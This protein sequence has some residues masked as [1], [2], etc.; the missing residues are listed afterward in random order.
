MNPK[1]AYNRKFDILIRA[2]AFTLTITFLSQ[3]IAWSYPD[4]S[5]LNHR[6]SL[7][8]KTLATTEDKV[9][10]FERV[11]LADIN[12]YIFGPKRDTYTLASIKQNLW[13]YI[14]SLAK[15]HGLIEGQMPKISDND[16][17]SDGF[18]IMTF[19]SGYEVLFYDPSIFKEDRRKE[20]NLARRDILNLPHINDYLSVQYSAQAPGDRD[21]TRLNDRGES[22]RL[23]DL[24]SLYSQEQIDRIFYEVLTKQVIN[25]YHLTVRSTLGE[26][27]RNEDIPSDIKKDLHDIL[28]DEYIKR[29]YGIEINPETRERIRRWHTFGEETYMTTRGEAHPEEYEI[30]LI[31]RFFTEVLEFPEFSNTMKDL[32]KKKKLNVLHVEDEGS[33][34]DAHAS[35]EFGINVCSS[36]PEE[37]IGPAIVHELMAY[38]GFADDTFN[39]YVAEIYR[40]CRKIW[41]GS[42][43]THIKGTNNIDRIKKRIEK[44]FDQQAKEASAEL[45]EDEVFDILDLGMPE[46][47]GVKI[48]KIEPFI[49]MEE[50]KSLNELM[51]PL[52]DAYVGQEQASRASKALLEVSNR[53]DLVRLQK[54]KISEWIPRL[55]ATCAFGGP[56]MQW[57]AEQYLIR[58]IGDCV[59]IPLDDIFYQFQVQNID[60]LGHRL[61]GENEILG[62]L[63][64][65]LEKAYLDEWSSPGKAEALCAQMTGAKIEDEPL[66][67]ERMIKEIAILSRRGRYFDSLDRSKFPDAPTLAGLAYRKACQLFQ[68]YMRRQARIQRDLIRKTGFMLNRYDYYKKEIEKEVR[69]M[70]ITIS[71][72]IERFAKPPFG[73]TIYRFTQKYIDYCRATEK[74]YALDGEFSKLTDSQ[75]P[76]MVRV[77]ELMRQETAIGH[78]RES[79]E[80]DFVQELLKISVY[81]RDFAKLAEGS[82]AGQILNNLRKIERNAEK[83]AQPLRNALMA[84]AASAPRLEDVKEEKREERVLLLDMPEGQAEKI[85]GLIEEHIIKPLTTIDQYGDET[86]RSNIKNLSIYGRDKIGVVRGRISAGALKSENV[87]VVTSESG[88]RSDFEHSK[89]FAKSFITAMS[90]IAEEDVYYPYLEAVF[91]AIM[92]ALG[93]SERDLIKIYE[94]IPNVEPRDEEALK[95]MCFDDEGKPKNYVILKLLPKPVKFDTKDLERTYERIEEFLRKA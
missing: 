78:E 30:H 28:I 35:P 81:N 4:L 45:R 13:P 52:R 72:N 15:A 41:D 46:K 57:E 75:T 65:A 33:I 8:Q 83:L 84:L 93:T 86:L 91:F 60:I 39:E 38:L 10:S 18:M 23:V 27:F 61:P 11:A 92:R 31:E 19:A 68:E 49:N 55:V 12:I 58:I 25:K 2:I 22:M 88:Y 16:Y 82:G 62:N 47:A 34:F 29:F 20:H 79:L 71:D 32:I 73:I 48:V 50:L 44:N 37:L 51:K 5:A 9:A 56:T 42:P 17:I 90:D 6:A 69:T 54:E 59:A 94:Q 3:G 63:E 77:N 43:N 1:I 66:R 80:K 76:D 53:D 87:I 70:L 36:C 89:E 24:G 85:K 95:K 7:A 26:I 14:L 40:V 21:L 74:Y 67:M 64:G